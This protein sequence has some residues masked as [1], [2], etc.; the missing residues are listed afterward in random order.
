MELIGC[1]F[2]LGAMFKSIKTNRKRSCVLLAILSV[3]WA[4]T[5]Q[6]EGADKLHTNK[7]CW[8]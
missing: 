6:R 7:S 3:G 1:A 2:V 5:E 8:G 4:P